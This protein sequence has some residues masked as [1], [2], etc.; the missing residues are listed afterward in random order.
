MSTSSNNQEIDP[1]NYISDTFHTLL[2]K[3]NKIGRA[4]V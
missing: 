4:H 1:R 3:E 2:S